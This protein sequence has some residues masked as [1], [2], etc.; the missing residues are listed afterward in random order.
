MGFGVEISHAFPNMQQKGSPFKGSAGGGGEVVR[1]FVRLDLS[2]KSLDSAA[3]I[4]A[5]RETIIHAV[6]SKIINTEAE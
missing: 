4:W 1:N 6:L 2:G 3:E 5:T